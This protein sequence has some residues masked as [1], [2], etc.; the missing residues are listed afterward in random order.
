MKPQMYPRLVHMGLGLIARANTPE[1]WRA[2][3]RE[4]VLGMVLCPILGI[5]L[6]AAIAY[7]T[8]PV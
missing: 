7:A 3:R 5:A 6:A 1:E 8:R 4:K 2:L